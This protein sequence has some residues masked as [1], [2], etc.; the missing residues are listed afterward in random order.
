[1]RLKWILY[2][3]ITPLFFLGQGRHESVRQLNSVIH[4]MDEAS[5]LNQTYYF[6]AVQ[7]AKAIYHSKEKINPNYFY[8]S[9]S[10]HGGYVY[11]TDMEKAFRFKELKPNADK[12]LPS[13]MADLIPYLEA[14]EWVMLQQNKPRPVFEK[15]IADAINRYII[16]TDS[17]FLLHSDLANYVADK[18]YIADPLFA[19]AKQLLKQ[20]ELYFEKCHQASEKLYVLLEH[21][22][23]QK[24]PLNKNHAALQLSEKEMKRTVDL[25][26]VWQT[27]LYKGNGS[28]NRN[29]D[30]LMRYLN[31]KGL[32][33]DSVYLYNTRGYSNLSSGWWLHSRYRSFYTMMQST[34]YWFYKERYSH[35]PYLKPE[36]ERYNKFILSYNSSMEYYNRFI[37]LADGKTM[38]KNSACCLSASEIDTSQNVMLQKPRL[39]Y[40]F[41]YVDDEQPNTKQVISIIQDSIHGADQE[42]V[43]AALPHHLVYLLDASSSMNEFGRLNSLK[44]NAGYL[45][46]L[47][48]QTDKISIISFATHA[49]VILKNEACH[50]KKSITESIEKIEAVGSTNITDGLLRAIQVADSGKIKDGK[51]TILLI[52][53]GFFKMDKSSYKQ[54]HSLREKGI[55]FCIIYLGTAHN[56]YADEHFKGM[57]EQ[58]NGRFYNINSVHL[59]EVLIK[60]ATE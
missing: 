58:A 36:D 42:L 4:L 11:Y 48:R 3:V 60:E 35:E 26:D 10:S 13:Y 32:S 15:S 49:H 24:L 57:M 16:L 44:E 37:E 14:K 52:T 17:L 53:D 46:K 19:K 47:Q 41:A 23:Q 28:Q 45:V 7:L 30:S 31:K 2:C 29:N 50:N 39:L 59:K 40:K 8:T 9:Q 55:G 1:M 56:S 6:D 54:L 33:K 38:I 20:H 22:Y 34:V 25:M 43:N 5:R 51:T 12:Q 27:Q 18:S 21:Y